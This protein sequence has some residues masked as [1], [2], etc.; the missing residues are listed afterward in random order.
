MRNNF[1]FG[2]KF[3]FETKFEIKIL[4]TKLLLH[5]GQIYWGSKLF[6]KSDKFPKILSYL[7][8][9]KCEFRLAW[10]YGEI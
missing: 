1:P 3:K 6:E 8:L 5:L 10:S 4:E 2:I 9:P 7:D